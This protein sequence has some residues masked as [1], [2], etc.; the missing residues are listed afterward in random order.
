MNFFGV[1]LLG[2]FTAG[3]VNVENNLP[4]SMAPGSKKLVELV[5]KKDQVQGF[6][7]LELTLPY[8]FNITPVDLK[9]A[10]FTFTAQKAKFVWMTIPT[11]DSF[12]VTY[13]LESADNMEGNY[14]INGV[15]SYVKENKRV[16]IKIP[17]KSV[18]VNK[19]MAPTIDEVA[20]T[21][22]N[23]KIEPELVEMV[24][25]RT[26][27]KVSDT[28]YLIKLKV[29]NNIIKDFGKILET[30]PNNCKT[31]KVS[32]EGAVVTQDKNTIKFVWFE[33]PKT[34]SFEVSYKILCLSPTINPVITGQLSY[35]DNGN[36]VS[37]NIVQGAINGTETLAA[38]TTEQKSN[39]QETKP[40]VKP[41]TTEVKTTQQP[42]P[43]VL[44]E[45]KTSVASNTQV[46]PKTTTTTNS[47]AVQSQNTGNNNS[48]VTAENNSKGKTPIT[49][50]P[51]AE[52]GITYKV[53]IMA[54]HRVVNKTY[55]KEKFNFEEQ[56]NIENH[57][58]WVKY[59]TGKFSEYKQARDAREEL[60]QNHRN[61]PGPFVT[62][63]NQGERI[64]VQ[65][66]LLISSQQWYK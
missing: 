17:P 61:L 65:E 18:F 20:Q 64:T 2:I 43:T 28:E 44:P 22:P 34:P 10:S 13:F 56:Y 14:S 8:G 25:E 4:E 35:V 47:T 63:Y 33:S 46:E 24:C 57:E 39:T 32:D 41:R 15:F 23:V 21:M 3:E 1:L 48:T 38:N 52:T 11:E 62:A 54:A 66:A 6:S 31:E 12:T 50:V 45:V 19:E 37:L 58:G 42:Q 30:V 55:L 49:K 26:I 53:Q 40:E 29:T 9:G 5:I 60:T 7:K 16:D 36:P 51:D 27:D 59:T